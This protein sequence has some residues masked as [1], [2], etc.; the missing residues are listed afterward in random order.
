M[1]LTRTCRLA[2]GFAL[3]LSAAPARGEAGP[4]DASRLEPLGAAPREGQTFAYRLSLASTGETA[5]AAIEVVL[6]PAA[7][8]V[9][10]EGLDGATLDADGR[11]VHWQGPLPAPTR[12]TVTLTLLAGLD[13]GGQSA[14]LH[15]TVRPWQGE[16]T[17]L[18]HV[19]EI[20]TVPAE[21]VVRLGRVGV[22]AAGLG[23]LSWLLG[24]TLFW[25]LLRVIRPR[26]ASWAA[27]AIMV[28]VGFLLYFAA[29]ARDDLRILALP[30]TTCTVIDRVIDSRTTSSSSGRRGGSETVYAP[31]LALRYADA[32]GA[33][34]AQGFGTGS[35]LSGASAS[36][37]TAVLE[38]YAIGEQVPCA[39]DAR[40][41]RIAY[42]ERGFGGAFFFALIP[43][44]LLLIGIWGLAA[45]GRG[46][47]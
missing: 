40:D 12:P 19:A 34:L 35:R 46:R 38:R 43:M 1:P 27:V 8:F 5:G 26:S 25:V 44:P 31:R 36:R 42:V 4:F 20:D 10:L 17:Y 15:V 30:E 47:R 7:M 33:R 24:A 37:A 45:G 41:P 22:T 29:L 13:A 9:S 16:T 11:Q 14:S 2:V 32:A 21:S 23:V 39:V 28:P 18:V 6:P 3:L